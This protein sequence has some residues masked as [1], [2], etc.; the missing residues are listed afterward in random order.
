MTNLILVDADKNPVKE[1]PTM[2]IQSQVLIEQMKIAKEAN[3]IVEQIKSHVRLTS[4]M[5]WFSHG[6]FTKV[7]NI[8]RRDA[9]E[10]EKLAIKLGATDAQL[11]ECYKSG[12]SI[13]VTT[14]D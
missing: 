13:H 9:K 10:L 6:I 1:L 5:K 3:A 4:A 2:A 11:A 8:N 14:K 7:V 12:S